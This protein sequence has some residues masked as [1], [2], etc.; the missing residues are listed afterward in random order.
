MI[1]QLGI[2]NVQITKLI[3]ANIIA[4]DI[5]HFHDR[6]WYLVIHVHRIQVHTAR[7][8]LAIWVVVGVDQ[9]DQVV[10]GL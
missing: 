1:R 7:S 4:I 5:L 8:G 9:N 2:I 3:H 6:R 10:D